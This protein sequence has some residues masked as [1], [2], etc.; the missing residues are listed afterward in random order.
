MIPPPQ[1]PPPPPEKKLKRVSLHS[2]PSMTERGES[3]IRIIFLARPRP[4]RAPA[5]APGR[6][7]H[8]GFN[9]TD[10]LSCF[11]DIADGARR[12]T[13]KLPFLF[14][15]ESS[16]SLGR[17]AEAASC[18]SS[19]HAAVRCCSGQ[20]CR[21]LAN[22][23]ALRSSARKSHPSRRSSVRLRWESFKKSPSAVCVSHFS[24]RGFGAL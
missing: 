23:C 9:I 20:E 5:L 10:E 15:F 7:L 21:R 4:M 17:R 11:S 3:L 6:P 1:R 2:D 22:G 12:H 19:K 16:D 18:A 8:V 13:M 14:S 24:L